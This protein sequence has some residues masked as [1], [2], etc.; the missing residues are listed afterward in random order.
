MDI[1]HATFDDFLSVYFNS[2]ILMDPA[3]HFSRPFVEFGRIPKNI[4]ATLEW[5]MPRIER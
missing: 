5:Q 2:I 4:S 3:L 1:F